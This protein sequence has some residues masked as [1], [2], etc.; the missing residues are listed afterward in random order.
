ML[1]NQ[2][3][4]ILASGNVPKRMGNAHPNVVPYQ[5]F[6][7]SDGHLIIACGNDRQFGMLCKVLGHT[8]LSA[9]AA[10]ATN[11]ARISN[12]IAL[13]DLISART[14][15]QKKK[16]LIAALEYAGVPSGPINN[17]E[18]AL[19]D[20]ADRGSRD[21]HHATGHSRTAYAYRVFSQPACPRQ[22]RADPSTRGARFSPPKPTRSLG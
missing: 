6:P 15:T 17:V 14:V 12:R 22:G 11:A 9:D 16:E 4:N 1:A 5:V 10:Y 7:A 8:D 18:E 13:C 19:S 2:A 20:P 21:A 3:M